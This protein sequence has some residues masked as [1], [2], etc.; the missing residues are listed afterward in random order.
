VSAVRRRGRRLIQINDQPAGAVRVLSVTEDQQMWWG[1]SWFAG[2]PFLPMLM[3]IVM[4]VIC[5]AVMSMMMGMQPPWRRFSGEPGK[6]ARDILDERYAS[7]AIDKF[8]Y[9]AKRRDLTA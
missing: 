5:V 2:M 7:G 3:M 4:V 1:P 6:T 9:E 8:E